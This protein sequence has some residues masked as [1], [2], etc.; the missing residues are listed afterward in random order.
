MKKRPFIYLILSIVLFSFCMQQWKENPNLPYP[1][2]PKSWLSEQLKKSQ[3]LSTSEQFKAIEKE[4][5]ILKNDAQVLPLGK[6]D[7]KIA[8]L[9]IGG[10][11]SEFKETISLF[12]QT[13]NFTF[14]NAEQ[15]PDSIYSQMEQFDLCL[16]SFHADSTES[17]TINK[18]QHT[19]LEKLPKNMEKI[20]V[21]FGEGEIFKSN[22]HSHCK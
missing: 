22:L 2:M 4:L 13:T 7:R 11:S 9:S 6:L 17:L 8:L 10:N 15:I 18:Q 19:V 16:I 3:N 12:A 14:H 1:P 20:S 21:I 5:V